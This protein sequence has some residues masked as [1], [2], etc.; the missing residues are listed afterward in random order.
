M[1]FG[2]AY[3]SA[4]HQ[5]LGTDDSTILFTDA[6]RKAAI[7]NGMLMFTDLTECLLRQSTVTCSNGVAEYNL[8]STVNVPGNDY[9]SLSKQGPEYHFTNDTGVIT[10]VAGPDMFPR[11]EIPWLN[12]YDPGWRTSTGATPQSYYERVDGGNR[13]IGLVPPPSFDSSESGKIVLPYIAK[14]VTMASDTDVPFSIATAPSTGIRND[15]EPYHQAV[16]HYA[17][18]ELEKLRLN[19]QASASQLQ[20]FMG[21]VERFLRRMQPKGPQQVRLG[22]NYF[23][24][25]KNRRGGIDVE[26]Q[27]PY[28]WRQ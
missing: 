18:H 23:S 24:E 5:E 6:R 3:S 11:R 28:P 17:A 20:I 22:R 7:N 4:L 14:P 15:L 9:L 12:Q 16:V 21:Y 10:Y 13:F 27:I 8:L 19:T 26:Q 1:N 25:V 2:H